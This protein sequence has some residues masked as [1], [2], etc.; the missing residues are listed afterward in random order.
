MQKAPQNK[1]LLLILDTGANVRVSS[2]IHCYIRWFTWPPSEDGE[3]GAEP[4]GSVHV[5]ASH[6]TVVAA[7]AALHGGAR[8]GRASTL[9][10]CGVT[11]A[12][13]C[14]IPLGA[15]VLAIQLS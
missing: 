9:R 15:L 3:P 6:S 10:R 14:Q 11:P 13:G 7:G 12:L 8:E 2:G 1:G 4:G 5:A